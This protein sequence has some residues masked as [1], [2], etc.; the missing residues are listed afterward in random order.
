MDSSEQDEVWYE[1]RLASLERFGF[2]RDAMLDFLNE[3]PNGR[4][5]RLSW[6]EERRETASEIEDRL[7]WLS[8]TSVGT[9]INGEDYTSRSHDVFQVEQLYSDFERALRDVAPWEPPLNRVKQSWYERDLGETWEELYRRLG[10][11]DESSHS[12]L[13]PLY[14]LFEHPER[15]DE[16]FRHLQTVLDDEERQRNMIE[17]GRALLAQGGHDVGP[18][19]SMS[20]LDALNHV[21]QWQEFHHAKEDLRLAIRQL[22]HPFDGSLA[23][24]FEVRCD[25]VNALDEKGELNGI[26]D[27]VNALAQTLELRRKELSEQLDRWRQQGI[28]F[29]HE[30][31]LH[32]SELMEWETN[33]DHVAS[34]VAVH[35]GLIQRWSRFETMWPSRVQASRDF[36]GHLDQTEALRDA[37]DELDL[38]WKE[39]ELDGLALIDTYEQAGLD[40][41]QWRQRIFDD[42]LTGL[43]MI[44]HERP[45]WDRRKELIEA[46]EA[47]DTSFDGV[48]DQE[49]RIHLLRGEVVNE[50]VMG[51]AEAYLDDVSRRHARHRV[52]L[53]EELAGFRRQGIL[54]EEVQTDSMSLKAFETYIASLQMNRSFEDEATESRPLPP[55]FLQGLRQELQGLEG[56]GW[57]VESWFVRM[58]KEP[59]EV[60]LE[61]SRARPF[62]EGHDVLRRRLQHL[63][64]GNDVQLGL[65]VERDMRQ[66]QMLEQLSAS[67][68]AYSSRLAGREVED[69]AYSIVLWQPKLTH[70]TLIP[71]KETLSSPNVPS[72]QS[73]LDD[74]HD[75]M[76]EAMEQ[77]EESEEAI[78]EAA[79]LNNETPALVKEVE[80][81]EEEGEAVKVEPVIEASLKPEVAPVPP[82]QKE[83]EVQI[84]EDGIIREDGL[85]DDEF[86]EDEKWSATR[87]SGWRDQQ[88]ALE[89]ARQEEDEFVEEEATRPIISETTQ[90]HKGEVVGE[91][92]LAGQ[93]TKESL[94]ALRE[95]LALL[96]LKDLAERIKNDGLEGV[97]FVRRGLAGH[98]NV[99]P[100]DVRVARLLRLTLRLLPEGNEGDGHRAELLNHLVNMIP[101]L[102]RWMRRRLEARHSGAQGHFLDDAVALGQ[103]L[104]RIPGLGKHVP[105]E[106]D[107]WPL[108]STLEEL[109][110]EIKRLSKSVMLPSAGGVKA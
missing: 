109:D 61:L 97:K 29:P 108:P 15:F 52:M 44:T 24:E 67:L 93:A 41:G 85:T 49:V 39:L 3:D 45:R 90:E 76:L 73:P 62:I 95:L 6:L 94:D 104:K 65:Q 33:H 1:N 30:G 14:N 98:V 70:A 59:M 86:W 36:L 43:E 53:E 13:T 51:E 81:A 55:R 92:E 12:A 100:R 58:E 28:F 4:S 38:L 74:A 19:G 66:P 11:L 35:L 75:A 68:P 22:I 34:S 79:P 32:P 23:T 101:P 31:E 88:E 40:L 26:R 77:V 72:I 54:R 7:I 64:W 60:A 102:K 78:E 47:L 105:L 46:L 18:V 5:E 56:K 80:V 71:V 25:H 9:R 84:R 106:K 8:R 99:T 42:P 87:W 91:K 83:S 107:E 20:L 57:N 103:A 27:E 10:R 48:E 63:P 110:K 2:R 17:Q 37:V 96:G 69:A 21:E 82:P 89:L 16:L 50:A